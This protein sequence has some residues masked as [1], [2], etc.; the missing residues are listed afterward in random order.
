MDITYN[1]L[2]RVFHL[3]RKKMA[4]V[5]QELINLTVKLQDNLKYQDDPC[6]LK[7]LIRDGVKNMKIIQRKSSRV[8]REVSQAA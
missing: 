3:R 5:N 1:D 6:M 2:R 7:I 8:Q 4:E